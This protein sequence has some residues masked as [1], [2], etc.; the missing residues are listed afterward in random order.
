MLMDEKGILTM[1]ALYSSLN[2]FT[3]SFAFIFNA[4]QVL[5]FSVIANSL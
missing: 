4:S 5:E 3:F 1:L 2:I